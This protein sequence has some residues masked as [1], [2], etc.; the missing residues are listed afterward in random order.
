MAALYVLVLHAV[1][2]SLIV[3]ATADPLHVLCLTEA[4]QSDAPVK[5]PTAHCQLSCCTTA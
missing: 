1:L 5:A 2:G 3:L 4:T